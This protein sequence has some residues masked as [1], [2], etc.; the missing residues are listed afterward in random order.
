MDSTPPVGAIKK[1]ESIRFTGDIDFS[2]LLETTCLDEGMRGQTQ[3]SRDPFELVILHPY[4]AFSVAAGSTLLAFEG[5]HEKR[6]KLKKAKKRQP[7]KHEIEKARKKSK[8][9]K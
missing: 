7:R 1:A 2:V 9:P 8:C 5:F 3:E 6:L 4:P